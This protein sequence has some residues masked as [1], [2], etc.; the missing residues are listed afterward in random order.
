MKKVL[1]FLASAII[2]LPLF[3]QWDGTSA[4][5]TQGNGTRNNPYQISTPN[6]LAYL[7]DMV[8]GGLN[9]YDGNYFILTTDLNFNNL[10]WVPIGDNNHPFKG[11]FDG[12]GHTINNI[13]ISNSNYYYQGLFGFIQ[14]DTIKNL[15]VSTTTNGGMTS[16]GVVG[17]ANASTIINCQANNCTINGGSVGGIV[18]NASNILIRNCQTSNCTL[19]CNSTNYGGG[20][21][22]YCSSSATINNCSIIHLTTIGNGY[23][24]GVIGSS[25]NTTTIKNCRINTEF[26]RGNGAGGIIYSNASNIT[27]DN[28]VV[29]IGEIKGSLSYSGG[30]IGVANNCTISNCDIYGRVISSHSTQGDAG[31]VV[32]QTSAANITN[33]IN[34]SK[35]QGSR[36]VGGIIGHATNTVN[37]SKCANLDSLV[38]QGGDRTTIVGGIIGDADSGGTVSLCYNIGHINVSGIFRHGTNHP[39]NTT[40][41]G[42][43]NTGNYDYRVYANGIGSS[44]QTFD[45]HHNYY[46]YYHEGYNY[47]TGHYERHNYSNNCYYSLTTPTDGLSISYCYNIGNISTPSYSGYNGSGSYE[48]VTGGARAMGIG[49]SNVSNSYSAGNISSGVIYGISENNPINSYYRDGCG[50]SNGGIPRAEAN[51]KSI[52]FP[53]ILNVDSIVFDMDINNE[54]EG[55]PI[56]HWSTK[57]KVYTDEVGNL[58]SYTASINGHFTGT[59][60]SCGF[61]FRQTGNDGSFTKMMISPNGTA[62]SYDISSLSA[63][64][65]YEYCFFKYWDGIAMYGDTLQFTTFPLYSVAVSSSNS[66]WGSVIGNGTFPHGTIDTLRA[67]AFANYRFLQWNDGNNNNPRYLTVTQ[68][69][70]LTAQFGPAIYNLTVVSNN[71]AWGS[72]SGSGSFNYN[73]SATITA[74]PAPHYHFVSWSDGNNNNPRTLIVTADLTLTATFAPDQYTVT[75]LPNNATYGSATGSGT[76]IYGDIDTLTATPFEH[77]RFTGWNDGNTNNPR[78]LTVTQDSSFTAMFVYDAYFLSLSVNNQ[79]WG[80]VS[81]GGM[82]EY[83]HQA[84]ATATPAEHYH[85]VSWDDG[86]TSNPRS[87]MITTDVS[88]QAIFAPD[89]Y[90]VTVQSSNP[91]WGSTTGSGSFAY[92]SIDTITATAIGQHV[93]AHWNDGTTSNPRHFTVLGDTTI[94][95]VFAPSS[96]TLTVTVNN[97]LWGSASGGGTFQYGQTAYCTAMA[98][99]GYHFVQ[100]SDGN[101]DN[102]RVYT[103]EDNTTL[104]AIFAPNQYTITLTA[105][106]TTKGSVSG[107]GTYDYQQQIYIIAIPADGYTF[108]QWSDGNTTSYRQITVT[109]DMTYTAVFTDIIYTITVTSSNPT[110]GYVTGGGQYARNSIA[111]LTAIPNQGYHFAQWSDGNTQNP[112][113]VTVTGNMTYFAQFAPDQYTIT[114]NSA[115]IGQGTATGSGVFGYGTQ[116][117][118]EATPMQHHRFLHWND[119]ITTNPR[120]ITVAGDSTFTAY[121]EPEEQYTVNVVSANPERGTVSG[122]GT[123]YNGEQITITASAFSGY[124]F[125]HWNDGNTEST[126]TIT[127]AHN[128]TYTAYFA[129]PTYTVNVSCNQNEGE[130][131][132]GG[133]YEQGATV[134]V[135]AT[136]KTG[137]HFTR[138]SNGVESDVY[139]FEIFNNVNLVAYF[140]STTGISDVENPFNVTVVG[141]LVT[142]TGADN[143][144]VLI[145]DIIGRTLYNSKQCNGETIDVQQSG[146][147]LIKVG[148]ATAKKIV[149]IK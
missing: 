46:H 100:W 121:F 3:A 40:E 38:S 139:S 126:R 4:P 20:I 83:G 84:T 7:A 144:P 30:I 88:L 75:S 123:Y 17:Y 59:A 132:G 91:A 149:I 68:N 129:A 50:A 61:L 60:D 53:M 55:Y 114:V 2:S 127:V 113:T 81:G 31:G 26:I 124:T 1:L 106:D 86:N 63:N 78:Y 67:T 71:N 14:S 24:A 119:G 54:N 90:T 136:P 99:A 115:N 39:I 98:N 79:A 117:T 41:E 141:T 32:A 102:P 148:N 147:Y 105:N 29:N 137:Y 52:S 51:M 134:T 82:Y 56:F 135:T 47:S 11:H 21:L 110:Y 142:I 133:T 128:T 103:L 120:I 10:S 19:T 28:C 73:A 70:T 58:H 34:Y 138:W 37:I 104:Q 116:T 18:G 25:Q 62:Y 27:I 33:C 6:Q 125:D 77:Y 130:V 9:E 118:I 8:C 109:Q 64:T 146:V 89:N 23:F 143:M 42:I 43:H 49:Y 112:R 13:N 74:T 35:I 15:I 101:T 76:F 94:T 95:A 111:T 97:T 36:Y 66:Q 122:G 65:Q 85:F 69:E 96:C 22:G 12:N 87:L 45:I 93:F 80:T 145:T 131:S 5:W 140:E 16:G 72:V 108:S 107:G 57:G 92:G 44:Y 48:S